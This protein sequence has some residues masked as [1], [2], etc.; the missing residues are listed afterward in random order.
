MFGVC[1]RKRV[2]DCV[3]VCVC[4]SVSEC[5][6]VRACACACAPTPSTD[7]QINKRQIMIFTD[8]SA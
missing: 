3:C 5:V 7:K 4:V 6:C 8:V 1:V 2:A